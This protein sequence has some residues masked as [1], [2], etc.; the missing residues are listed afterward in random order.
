MAA[1]RGCPR[2]GQQLPWGQPDCPYCAGR[3]AWTLRRDTF[4]LLVGV[5]LIALFL[6]TGSTVKR[7][8]ELQKAFA[9]EWYSRGEQD[10]R[11]KRLVA[12]LAD[13]RTALTYSHNNPQ[14][15][16]RLAQALAQMGDSPEARAEARTYL[17]NL[18]EREP[19]NGLVNLELARLAAL[20]HDVG[21]A[22]RYYHAAIYGA[23]GGHQVEQRRAAR[24]EL[25]QF[26]LDSGQKDAARA[27]LIAMAP[28]LPADPQLQTRVADLLIRV[29]GCDDA[30]KLFHRALLESPHSPAALAGAGECHYQ[31]G[32][33]AQAERYLTRAVQQDPGLTEAARLRDSARAVLELDPFGHRLSN[34]ER[35]HRA[36][37]D[38]QTATARLTRCTAGTSLEAAGSG[39]LQTLVSQ[40]R[41]L[42]PRVQERYLSR[43][44]DLLAQVMEIVFAVELTTSRYCSPPQGRDVAL[45]LLAEEPEG[46]R[47]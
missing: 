10:L 29:H 38:F 31:Q 27:E 23:W 2:C 21:G 37:L 11:A 35:A 16:L 22:L 3:F 39:Q 4:L 18:L 5:L 12:A 7:Y 1:E 41:E 40:V 47:P 6:V 45:L 33:Y 24:L 43:D 14:Y 19:G 32:N 8:F 13:F 44:P 28:D 9:E 25:V 36:A 26:L 34:A 46:N 15:E 42:Q 30:L 20:D 17:L